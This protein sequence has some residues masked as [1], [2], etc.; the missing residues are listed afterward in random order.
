MLL[1][2]RLLYFEE[3]FCFFFIHSSRLL[4]VT[5]LLWS[6][7]FLRAKIM[8]FHT[9]PPPCLWFCSYSLWR[10]NRPRAAILHLCARMWFEVTILGTCMSISCHFSLELLTWEEEKGE[11]EEGRGK[12]FLGS[13]FPWFLVTEPFR[14][15]SRSCRVSPLPNYSA[16]LFV[17]LCTAK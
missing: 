13:H 14:S 16:M 17:L 2:T 6:S 5:P 1:E 8:G 9:G 10:H 4:S 11:F 7:D 12:L 3:D 15:T